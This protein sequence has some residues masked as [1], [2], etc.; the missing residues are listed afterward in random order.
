MPNYPGQ[1][2]HIHKHKACITDP[3]FMLTPFSFSV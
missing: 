1:N 2:N 3:Q